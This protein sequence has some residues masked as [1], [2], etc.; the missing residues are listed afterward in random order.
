MSVPPRQR[1]GV[2]RLAFLGLSLW[3]AGLFVQPARADDKPAPSPWE[4]EVAAFEKQDREK[5]P[6]KSP[7]VFVGSSSIQLWDL[8]KSFP[9]MKVINRGIGGSKIIDAV[10]LAPQIVLKYE[11]RLIVFYAGDN[12]IAFGRS[13]DQVADDFRTFVEVVHKELPKTKIVFLSIKPS[14]RRWHLWEKMQK[15]NSLIEEECK[16]DQHLKYVDVAKPMLDDDGKPRPEL[17]GG[18]GLHLNAKGYKVWAA[19][20]APLLK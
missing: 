5:P 15:A 13:P 1:A 11:P 7:I 3:T 9:G 19:V 12:D 6:P 4:K 2:F 18:D 10:R 14:V 20:V 16:N 17:F 8:A